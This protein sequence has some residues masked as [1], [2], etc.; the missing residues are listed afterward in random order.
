MGATHKFY[1]TDYRPTT[2]LQLDL[3][4]SALRFSRLYALNASLGGINYVWPTTITAGY[5]LKALST[6]TLGWSDPAPSFVSVAKWGT[7]TL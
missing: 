5:V 4:T 7:V 1:N 3:G 6:T 2:D